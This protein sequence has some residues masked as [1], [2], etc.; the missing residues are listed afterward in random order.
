[1]LFGTCAG[2]LNLK[3][4]RVDGEGAGVRLH[5]GVHVVLLV[6]GDVKQVV[7]P[8]EQNANKVQGFFPFYILQNLKARVLIVE[9][10][11]QL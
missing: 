11:L 5:L 2:L 10:R 8:G 3:E 1:M 6:L 9:Y 7:F 4:V